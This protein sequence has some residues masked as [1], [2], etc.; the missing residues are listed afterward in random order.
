MS[1]SSI[2]NLAPDTL[3]SERAKTID[4]TNCEWDSEHANIQLCNSTSTRK[5]ELPLEMA[6]IQRD[7]E[8]K[9]RRSSVQTCPAQG[10]IV[11]EES[12]ARIVK[13]SLFVTA[14]RVL[15]LLLVGLIFVPVICLAWFSVW[16]TRPH[17]TVQETVNDDQG[18]SIGAI[19][20]KNAAGKARLVPP[21]IGTL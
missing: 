10:L 15:F 1:E 17:E 11:E 3:D 13:T 4:N 16:I 7:Q 5:T 8:E 14:I 12:S 19:K 6:V 20:L 2:I 18:N 9:C 21:Q